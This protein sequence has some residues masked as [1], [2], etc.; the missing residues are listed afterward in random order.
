MSLIISSSII[1]ASA[2]N[3]QKFLTPINGYRL[4][5]PYSSWLEIF[6]RVGL[7][8]KKR[9]FGFLNKPPPKMCLSGLASLRQRSQLSKPLKRSC[10][11]LGIFGVISQLAEEVGFPSACSG[12]VIP[13]HQAP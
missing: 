12:Q 2:I 5:P 13:P 9:Y 3:F 8:N 1:P 11:C 6:W 10:S 4:L 7:I